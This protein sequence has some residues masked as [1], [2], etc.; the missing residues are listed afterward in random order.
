MLATFQALVVL[1]TSVLPG[2]LFT[3]EYERE[4]TRAVSDDSNERLIV[5]LTTSAVFGM[6]SLPLLYQGYRKYIVTGHLRDGEPLPWWI[7]AIVVAYV[8]VPLL[9]GFLA[10]SAAR[11]RK[12]GSRLLTG[13]RPHPTAWDALFRTPKLGGLLRLTLNDG[14]LILGEWATGETGSTVPDSYAS[15]YP[16]TQD[17]YLRETFAL[18]DDGSVEL[19]ENGKTVPRGLAVL[20]SWSEVAYAE[21]EA[22]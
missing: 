11:E 1:L 12:W 17:L 15:A 2:A 4:Y 16:H 13:P 18:R 14:T 6:V 21:F 19:D 3:F 22:L 7:W 9:V 20:I 5:F 10:G 8:V